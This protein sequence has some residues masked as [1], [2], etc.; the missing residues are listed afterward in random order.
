MKTT[1]YLYQIH[2]EILK[3]V[4]YEQALL[5]KIQGAD[6]VL[7]QLLDAPLIDRDLKRVKDVC[8]AID[9]NRSLLNELTSNV[10]KSNNADYSPLGVI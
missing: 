10:T 5:A 4:P 3:G 7:R 1:E 2:P 8:D 9:H 6:Y